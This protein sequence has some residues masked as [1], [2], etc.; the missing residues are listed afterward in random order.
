MAF[1]FFLDKETYLCNYALVQEINP[2]AGVIL[3]TL[4]LTNEEAE[5]E[6]REFFGYFL[7]FYF[8]ET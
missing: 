8:K 4:S 5:A 2:T 1:I 3:W 7:R 6:Q